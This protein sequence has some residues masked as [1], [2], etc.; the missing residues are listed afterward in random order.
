MK[1]GLLFLALSAVLSAQPFEGEVVDSVTGAPIAGAYV[2]PLGFGKTAAI[3]DS[4]GHFRLSEPGRAWV[5]RAGYLSGYMWRTD[6]SPSLHAVL[7]PQAVIFGKVV[8]EDGFPAEGVGILAL[9]LGTIHGQRQWRRAAAAYTNDLGEFRVTRLQAGRY[10]LREVPLG[11]VT[12]W[13]RR[14]V[15][16]YHPGTFDPR[17]ATVI[18]VKAGQ[19]RRVDVQLAKFRSARVSGQVI[20]PAGADSSP[21]A[22]LFITLVS[23]DPLAAYSRLPGAVLRHEDGSFVFAAV[24]PGR[25]VVQALYGHRLLQPGDWLAEQRAEVSSADIDGIV[26]RPS[27]ISTVDLPGTVVFEGGAKPQRVYVTVAPVSRNG[28]QTVQMNDDGSFV[29][30]GML[31][32]RYRIA[33]GFEP[34]AETAAAEPPPLLTSVRLGD[35]E[36]FEDD[37]DFDGASEGPLRIAFTGGI[38]VSGKLLD[39][40]GQ[41]ATGNAVVFVRDGATSTRST[42]VRAG[43]DGAFHCWLAPGD[44]HAYPQLP[45]Q[46]TWDLGEDSDFLDAHAKDFPPV[47]VVAGANP[48]LALRLPAQQ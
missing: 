7:A 37:F 18:E 11:F 1:A 31:P 38:D 32:W 30:K 27:A 41:P 45:G 26:L 44:Y 15:M 14:Y 19:E 36:I 42:G 8:D 43:A 34:G 25:Y 9:R 21:G 48:P 23:P 2:L 20:S 13:D 12:D 39:A 16:A 6:G 4:S 40:A 24:P 5:S 28:P 17:E 10:I 35:K 46:N 33:V 29:V 47:H 3:S 22:P